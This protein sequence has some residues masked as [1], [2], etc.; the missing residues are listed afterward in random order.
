MTKPMT[1]DE[2]RKDL[3]ERALNHERFM[4]WFENKFCKYDTPL[5]HEDYR[6]LDESLSKLDAE[7][8]EDD[9]EGSVPDSSG[10][11]QCGAP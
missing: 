2:A 9:E 6:V 11:S 3:P 8:A 4:Q 10:G 1:K 7:L 5:D